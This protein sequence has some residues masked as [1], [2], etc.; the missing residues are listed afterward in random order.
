MH[1]STHNYRHSQTP[2]C[3]MLKSAA[4]NSATPP[5]YYS[6]LQQHNFF[7]INAIQAIYSIFQLT[8]STIKHPIF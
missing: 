4:T 3:Q 6:A 2:F 8:K 1:K 7:I 5:Y